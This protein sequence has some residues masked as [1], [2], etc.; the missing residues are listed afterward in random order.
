MPSE[1]IEARLAVEVALCANALR[2]H[3]IE[4]AAGAMS[5]MLEL[6]EEHR[7]VLEETHVRATAILLDALLAVSRSGDLYDPVSREL[8][9][10]L[11]PTTRERVLH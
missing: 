4:E 6:C 10:E 11:Y 9:L 1:E 7:Y 5:R 3:A 8:D 2:R